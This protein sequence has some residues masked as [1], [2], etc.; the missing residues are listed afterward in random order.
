[1]SGSSREV[2]DGEHAGAQ[3][4]IDV[5]GVI[6]DVVGDGAGLGL[7]TGELGEREVLASAIF[8][9]LLGHAALYRLCRPAARRQA[10]CVD[11]RPIV[12]GQALEGLPGEVEAVEAGIAALQAGDHRQR[13]GVV[14]ESA[15]SGE[16]SIECALAGMAE[17]RMAE[18]MGERAGLR[19][20]LVE[21]ERARQ[22]ARDLGDFEGVGEPGAIVVA[23]VVDEHLRLVGKPAEGGGMDD[24][25]AIAAEIAAGGARRLRMEPA[26]ARRG[27][28]GIGRA[29]AAAAYRHCVTPL[30]VDLAPHRT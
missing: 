27:V 25:V 21:A 6:G 14:V 12:L 30:A 23:L 10:R 4:V 13:L 16:A 9:D 11:Q 17:R 19:E 22:R 26:P 3:P 1:M 8:A 5:V 2:V 20:I 24:P 7:R 18:V 15:M 29:R 28:R